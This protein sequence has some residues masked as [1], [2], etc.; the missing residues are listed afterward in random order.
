MPGG[1]FLS[2]VGK[3]ATQPN[4]LVALIPLGATLLAIGLLTLGVGLLTT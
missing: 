2:V 1:F 4:R 3:G